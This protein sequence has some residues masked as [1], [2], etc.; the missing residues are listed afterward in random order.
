MVDLVRSTIAI[1]ESV[2]LVHWPICLKKGH[3]M[4]PTK[5]DYTG[6]LW[7]EHSRH[8]GHPPKFYRVQDAISSNNSGFWY[9]FRVILI[10]DH[11]NTCL[12]AKVTFNKQ[13]KNMAGSLQTVVRSGEAP[14]MVPFSKFGN[15]QIQIVF[16]EN[17]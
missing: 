1:P 11:Q 4:P 5:D 7:D 13:K 2:H 12:G 6:R 17:Q 14:Q 9:H 16:H 10:K 8:L 15:W 3:P